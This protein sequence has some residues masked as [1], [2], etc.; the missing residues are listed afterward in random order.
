MR[1]LL[2]FYIF[3]VSLCAHQLRENYLR[4]DY[5][6]TT[7]N[8][9]ID[10]EVETRLLENS[11]IDDNHN[12]IISFKELRHHKKNLLHYAI[13]HIEFF[14]HG[15]KLTLDGA[16]VTFHRYQ[17][18]TYMQIEKSFKDIELYG[19]K[20][21]YSMFFEL[22]KKHKLL[23]H[24]T[25]KRDVILDNEHR[26]YLFL[27]TT[28]TQFQ[29]FK[30]FVQEGIYHILDGTDHLLFILMLLIPSVVKYVGTFHGIRKSF[31]SLLKI[32]T[33]FSIAHSLT[34]FIA[35]MGWYVPNTTFIESGIAFSIFIV[36][37]LNYLQKYGHVS[38]LIV[39]FFGLIHG[40]GFANV[41]EIA[42]VSNVFSFVVALFGFNIGVEIGQ[43][44]VIFVLIPILFF[45]MKLSY[46]DRI[47]KL[48]TLGTMFIAAVWF[49]QRVGLI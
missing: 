41:L 37:L 14:Y 15:K 49:M 40:F 5:N 3:I 34:L 26:K 18:Q 48:I 44:S 8:L 2:L 28:M 43:I 4:V 10:F 38:Y 42:G 17:D 23:I 13:K 1:F 20:L 24:I 30:V 39:F 36:A 33:T 32:I 19:L 11:N 16:K 47:L 7:Q 21:H 31:L 22:E 25:Q 6:A 35:G 27:S 46:R 9:L 29:R 45:I 12:E